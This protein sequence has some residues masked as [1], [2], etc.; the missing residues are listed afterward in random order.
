MPISYLMRVPT[1]QPSTQLRV[2]PALRFKSRT[3]QI[4]GY[5]HHDLA[6]TW[7]GAAYQKQALFPKLETLKQTRDS[8]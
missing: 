5:G 1:F 6:S 7:S 3:I 8:K 4:Y 2:S